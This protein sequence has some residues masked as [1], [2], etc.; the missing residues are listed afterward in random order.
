MTKETIKMTDELF[1]DLLFE[2]G[3]I[4]IDE[5]FTGFRQ[6]CVFLDVVSKRM[7]D[8][9]FFQYDYTKSYNE[10]GIH[11]SDMLIEVF[12]VE[13]TITVYE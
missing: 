13:K 11:P 12:P 4:T 7:S 1:S 3:W 8:G 5:E 9:K 10:G 6:N 2:N